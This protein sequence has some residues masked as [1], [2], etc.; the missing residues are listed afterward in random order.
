MTVR[1]NSG[2]D[3]AG[4]VFLPLCASALFLK[5]FIGFEFL[6]IPSVFIVFYY[7]LITTVS[8]TV[9]SDH[10]PNLH[11]R[12]LMFHVFITKS[13]TILMREWIHFN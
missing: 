1:R 11:F 2:T 8:A 4:L 6:E 12:L 9:I 5:S 13:T 3:W 10:L 7:Y